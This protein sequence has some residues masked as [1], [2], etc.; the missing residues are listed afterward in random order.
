MELIFIICFQVEVDNLRR[1][2][3]MLRDNSG[4][5]GGTGSRS[6][7]SSTA[8]NR[9][10]SRELRIAATTAENNLRY[11]LQFYLENLMLI[12]IIC[13]FKFLDNFC[14]EWTT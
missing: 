7:I 11:Y 2:N 12:R 5:I 8:Q 1:D 6:S 9:Q 13:I 3:E 10:F 4:A 14:M